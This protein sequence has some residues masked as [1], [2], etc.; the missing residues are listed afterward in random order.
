MISVSIYESLAPAEHD[1]KGVR[2]KGHWIKS[3]VRSRPGINICTYFF[4]EIAEDIESL[5][6]AYSPLADADIKY[7]LYTF[8]GK[9]KA[10][11][12]HWCL[13]LVLHKLVVMTGVAAFKMGY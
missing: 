8:T 1:K 11:I 6:P 12:L 5:L 3:N 10:G 7:N 2:V 13:F 9:N 4:H